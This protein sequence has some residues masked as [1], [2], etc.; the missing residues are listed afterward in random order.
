MK[1]IHNIALDVSRQGIQATIP[2]TR[3][4]NGVRKLIITLRNKGE[5]IELTEY[6]SAAL[7]LD[8]DAFEPVIV[9][10]S[11]GAYPNSLV[12]D[13]TANASATAGCKRATIQ[14]SRYSA[15]IGS[16]SIAFSADIA[17]NVCNNSTYDSAVLDSPPY[18]AVLVAQMATEQQ[19]IA[20]EKHA[21]TAIEHAKTAVEHA[22]IAVEHAVT[23][24]KYA[25][26]TET[27]KDQAKISEENTKKYEE[28]VKKSEDALRSYSDD[29][30]NILRDELQI[31]ADSADDELEAELSEKIADVESIAK[32]ANQAVSFADYQTM[33]T[34]LNGLPKDKYTVGQ[35]V[36]IVT[37]NVPDLWISNVADTAET[38]TYSDDGNFVGALKKLG[39][40]QVGYFVLSAL[41]TQKVD[42]TEYA[43]T[44]EVKEYYGEPLPL[45]K[46][47]GKNSVQIEGNKS[48]SGAYSLQ[49][50]QSNTNTGAKSIVAG[51][52]CTNNGENSIVSGNALECKTN[53]TIAVGQ[54]NKTTNGSNQ[55]IFGGYNT[56]NAG[57][58]LI[59]GGNNTGNH[60]F[61]F[62]A[63]QGHTT[64][65]QYQ[66]LLG[67]Y[68]QP[69]VNTLLA[70]G[71]GSSGAPNNAFEVLEDG[72]AKLGDN[73]V[74]TNDYVDTM[75][76]GIGSVA[77]TINAGAI[78][79]FILSHNFETNQ[80]GGAGVYLI[81]TGGSSA[82]TLDIID[83]DTG[84]VKTTKAKFMILAL[85]PYENNY[86]RF[87]A[88]VAY[89]NGSLISGAGYSRIDT[90][91]GKSITITAPS[92]AVTHVSHFNGAFG[93]SFP[94]D[95]FIKGQWALNTLNF[96]T[97][98]A[99]YSVSFKF[100]GNQY[101]KLSVRLEGS[102]KYMFFDDYYDG[103][104]ARPNESSILL[105]FGD[106]LQE[107]TS[108]FMELM[109][110]NGGPIE[111]IRKATITVSGGMYGS[112]SYT[113]EIEFIDGQTWEAL[114]NT[115]QF[116][117]HLTCIAEG[118]VYHSD[119]AAYWQL[120]TDSGNVVDVL[121]TDKI[122][123]DGNYVAIGPQ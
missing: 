78:K 113:G 40:V 51:Q 43:K 121:A 22:T 63:G 75:V 120:V 60:A 69:T 35:N 14:I 33:V 6:D 97:A 8:T 9:Y 67:S 44:E 104:G 107:V 12:Y 76:K 93:V 85:A 88:T 68:S 119:A 41:E 19:A 28:N 18:A 111:N 95:T 99:D 87:K 77:L 101:S 61:S 91:V 58:N 7:Y 5:P 10:T 118:K 89:Y 37:L 11:N 16:T 84:D 25:T 27:A 39:S 49:A 65:R 108:E 114:N 30:D 50:G 81:Y 1:I 122:V 117:A 90:L 64:T 100:E 36:M 74:A 48:N 17:F 29:Q 46:G 38:F 96:V 15:A 59:A 4:E 24:E 105:D 3:G 57:N 56:S 62:M 80:Y 73:T 54:T 52:G 94:K 23:A 115:S 106:T 42:L 32:G 82:T 66:T 71:N 53:G 86:S 21:T 26:E 47:S 103:Y 45:K 79:S 13:V 116:S 83:A 20:A 31:Y 55:A 112:S 72:T 98:D 34:A 2:I 102:E 110:K 92:D 70:I 123:P 109:R